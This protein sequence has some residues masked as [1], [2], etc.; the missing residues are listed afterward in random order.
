MTSVASPSDPSLTKAKFHNFFLVVA[1][2]SENE[3]IALTL[4]S[5]SSEKVEEEAPLL[6]P[7]FSPFDRFLI[8]FLR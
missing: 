4:V 2:L 6:Q 7:L 1:F 8:A 3:S 5:K